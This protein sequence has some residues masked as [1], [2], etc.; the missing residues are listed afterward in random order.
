MVLPRIILNGINLYNFFFMDV[1]VY[2][3]AIH[4][5]AIRFGPIVS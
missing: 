2:Y 3:H 5:F 1:L 4:V